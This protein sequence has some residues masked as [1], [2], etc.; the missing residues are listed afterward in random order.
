MS[1]CSI[2]LGSE[3]YYGSCDFSEIRVVKA[4]K[5]HR[6]GECRQE[7]PVKS[8]YEYIAAKFDGDF[9]TVK[10][11]L[12]CAEIR[13]VFVDGALN[14]GDLWYEM[15]E[16]GFPSFSEGCLVNLETSQAKQKLVDQWRRWKGLV[17]PTRNA[18]SAPISA[19]I[20]S[21]P[22]GE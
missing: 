6:C 2:S 10:T 18:G 16:H 9:F 14:Y 13:R 3:D 1:E 17:E 20:V 8:E 19:G 11:C 22:K 5:P 21:A 12:A 15:R 7:I 4:R